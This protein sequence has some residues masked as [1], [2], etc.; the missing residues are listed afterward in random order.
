MMD[1]ATA[2]K[3]AAERPA[4]EGSSRLDLLDRLLDLDRPDRCVEV[5]FAWLA[6]VQSIDR[7]FFA[8][9]S[10]ESGCLAGLA[11]LGVD[12]AAVES[13]CR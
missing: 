8:A 9:V 5:A 3:P 12:Q 4:N 10:E 1:R 11:G 2:A 13:F 7:A 6:D